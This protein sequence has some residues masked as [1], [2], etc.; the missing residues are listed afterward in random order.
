MQPDQ[1]LISNTEIAELAGVGR[2]TVSNW[3]KRHPDFPAPAGRGA[4]GALYDR[5]EVLSW[6]A[7]RDS[8]AELTTVLWSWAD[9][10]RNRGESVE[11]AVAD[12]VHQLAD[13]QARSSI[14]EP[15]ARHLQDDASRKKAADLLLGWSVDSRSADMFATPPAVASLMAA[16]LEPHGAVLDMA[17]GVGSLLERCADD[18]DEVC[19]QEINARTAQLCRDRLSICGHRSDIRE[20]DTLRD[21]KFAGRLFD[22]VISAPPFNMRLE[23]GLHE[24][25]PRWQYVLPRRVADEAWVQHALAHLNN[26]GRAVLL[27]LPSLLFRSGD[28]A[29]LRSS[30]IRAGLIRAVLQ[31]PG[32]SLTV[33]AVA[34][35]ILVLGNPPERTDRRVLFAE[36]PLQVPKRR[37][38]APEWSKD[39]TDA[40]VE[41]VLAWLNDSREPSDVEWAA[42]ASLEELAETDFVLSPQRHLTAQPDTRPLSKL[43]DEIADVTQHASALATALAT[44]ITSIPQLLPTAPVA[45]PRV[46]L[47]ELQSISLDKVG[48]RMAHA[49]D[50]GTIPIETIGT[51]ARGVEPTKYLAPDAPELQTTSPMFDC[52]PGDLLV[53]LDAEPGFTHL[54]TTD[55]FVGTGFAR[56]RPDD[57]EQ[58]TNLIR[59]LRAW[60]SSPEGKAAIA[61]I[62]SGSTLRRISYRDF[63]QLEVPV[64]PPEVCGTLAELDDLLT[65]VD[66]A[67]HDLIAALSTTNEL[68]AELINA[69]TPVDD[70]HE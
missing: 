44:K 13:P 63:K 16:V 22:G 64:P 15:L 8:S 27:T 34:P 54:A 35:V 49:I 52:R 3:K 4:R 30:L 60:F 43:S 42:V 2:S 21:D 50:E 25:D 19:G 67:R 17:C 45:T 6:L 51:L 12:L 24:A 66:Q 20:G 62:A 46:R 18:A 55:L 48:V 14:G 28:A 41:P 40:V 37:T 38:S 11:D 65:N 36:L 47:S 56:I 9:A 26:D 39:E 61:R 7:G 53:A 23:E 32:A 59:F 68:S 10:Q 5:G 1:D 70:P 58:S 57:S 69:A 33:T 29:R 31:L